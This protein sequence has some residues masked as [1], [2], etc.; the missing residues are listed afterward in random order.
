MLCRIFPLLT[1]VLTLRA[2]A[3][4]FPFTQTPPESDTDANATVIVYNEADPDSRLLAE[5]YADK[6]SVPKEQIVA[7][8]CS[9]KE[10]ISRQEYDDTIAEPMLRAFTGNFWW[11]LRE[12]DGESGPVEKN[13]IRYVVLMRGV[14][15]KIA[16]ANNYSGDK[17]FSTS[18]IGVHNEASVDSE[19]CVLGYRLRTISGAVNNPF[20]RSYTAFR[21][22]HR[23]DLL[24][25][26]RLDGPSATT[27][28]RMIVD[29]LNVE[30]A[31]GLRGFAYIDA[32]GIAT[33]DPG[34]YEGDQ[35]L[36]SAAQ[37]LRRIG[38]PVILDNGPALFPEG[39]PMRWAALYLGW[40]S[41]HAA[42]PFIRPGFR[43][44]PGAIAVHIHSFSASTVRDAKANWVGPLLEAGAAATLGNVYEP[45][46]GLTRTWIS[47]K[48]G[49]AWVSISPKA[50]TPRS[51]CFPG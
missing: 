45:Y 14:P 6:R 1:L 51:G 13:R 36:L 24:M 40:Y 35:W 42:G 19:L 21:E 39:Y 3:D 20:Y 7:L 25:V 37:D 32:R 16:P 48:S 18:P 4:P 8:K 15:L 30:A 31:G 46:L 33:T 38:M 9:T 47:S 28:R 26:C 23:P 49:C 41:E 10:E 29:A 50:P 12:N 11:K 17:P 22:A 34:L 5:F 43:F 2:A 27:V 44:V